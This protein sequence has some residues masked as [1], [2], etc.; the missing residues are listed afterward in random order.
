M[1]RI[2]ANLSKIFHRLHRGEFVM[3]SLGMFEAEDEE[4]GVTPWYAKFD[5]DAIFNEEIA[6]ALRPEP[7]LDPDRIADGHDVVPLENSILDDV[8]FFRYHLVAPHHAAAGHLAH[9]HAPAQHTAPS[10]AR[11][12]LRSA[13]RYGI[14][15]FPS[16]E[17]GLELRSTRRRW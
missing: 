12:S 7:A 9:T 13:S 11:V 16:R 4:D 10:L 3:R 14:D 5:V 15:G 17:G 8:E 6:L 1:P 2:H